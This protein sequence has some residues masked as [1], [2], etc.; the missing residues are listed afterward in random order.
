M[1]AER[2][3][4]FP[5][6]LAAL[7]AGF[8]ITA[9]VLVGVRGFMGGSQASKQTAQ[10]PADQ[11]PLAVPSGEPVDVRDDSFL[12]GQTQPSGG[13]AGDATSR[14]SEFVEPSS[15]EMP[16]APPLAATDTPVERPLAD[17]L[18]SSAP[19]DLD[20]A[21]LDPPD[22]L[23]EAVAAAETPRPAA[24]D[25]T[26]GVAAAPTATVE[27][28]DGDE[29]A[30]ED[31]PRDNWPAEQQPKDLGRFASEDQ[32][33][34]VWAEGPQAW[35]RL[36]ARAVLVDGVHL[37]V[38]TLFRPNLMLG[39]GIH[40]TLNDR[41][42]VRLEAAENGD[43]QIVFAF[44][45]AIFSTIGDTQAVA[46]QLGGLPVTVTFGDAQSQL[47]LEVQKQRL[48]GD[49]PFQV[50]SSAE[51]ARIWSTSGNIGIQIG[52]GP[53]QSVASGNVWVLNGGAAAINEVAAQPDWVTVPKR[54]E[55]DRQAVARLASTIK[56]DRS[57]TLE[58]FEVVEHG[59]RN[60]LRS[61]AARALA[62]LGQFDPLIES[63]S[64]KKQ[65]YAWNAHYEEL[66]AGLARDPQSAERVREAANKYWGASAARLLRMV[67]GYDPERL[68]SVGA[69]ELVAALSDEQ[70]EARVIA[71]ETLRRI[72]GKSQLFF[73]ERAGVRRR[74]PTRKWQQLLES[75]EIVYRQWPPGDAS[76]APP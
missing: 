29:A 25:A 64:D 75:G 45:Q 61:L 5:G 30:V 53:L 39:S 11:A 74:E 47:A 27:P 67:I 62:S 68:R 70:L 42:D 17:Q 38:P 73:P 69:A 21:E 52:A 37:R 41:T 3:S 32:L 14:Q 51:Q 49:D 71:I 35:Q 63:F 60:E 19:A 23:A 15:N 4:R 76:D 24:M 54:R 31:L 18:R 2:R 9:A 56:S 59:R 22:L 50:G 55:I 72:T 10:A 48:P 43:T 58:L 44:G 20:T 46:L 57:M 26:T 7:I 40:V 13:A 33:L 8:L 66:L 28:L 16:I 1:A 12:P 36:P 6:W 65:H 34:A